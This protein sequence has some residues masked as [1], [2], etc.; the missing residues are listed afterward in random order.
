MFLFNRYTPPEL[1]LFSHL[2][3]A[4]ADAVTFRNSH[5]ST[6]VI[7]HSPPLIYPFKIRLPTCNIGENEFI[8]KNPRNTMKTFL[9]VVE[10]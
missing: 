10:Y 9:K 2:N 6:I 8:H 5:K 4:R 3:I 7:L 1:R